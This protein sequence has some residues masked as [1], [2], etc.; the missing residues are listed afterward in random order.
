[1]TDLTFAAFAY[2]RLP[3]ALAILAFAMGAAG[4]WATSSRLR[5]ASILA[6][7]VVFFGAARLAL[8]VFDPYLSS[9]VLAERL[10]QLP[11]GTLI[12]NGQYYDFSS[13]PFYTEYQPLLLNGRVNNLEYGSYAPG[14]PPVFIE[15]AQFSEIWRSGVK[16][17]AITYDEK[18][19]ELVKLVGQDHLYLVARSGGKQLL[20]NWQ[21]SDG[22]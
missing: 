18:S 5:V 6:M 14:A 2:L 20:A 13:V 22:K 21:W 17:F 19:N 10:R 7:L 15:D 1:M 12:F 9:Y 4:V 16:T 11:R 3:L 8:V